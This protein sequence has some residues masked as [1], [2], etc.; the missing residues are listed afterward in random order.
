MLFQGKKALL[1]E[2]WREENS[3]K[4]KGEVKHGFE[5]VEEN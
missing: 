5:T 1:T 2:N 4:W 3:E